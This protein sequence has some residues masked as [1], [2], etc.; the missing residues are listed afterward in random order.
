MIA[1]VTALLHSVLQITNQAS[2]LLHLVEVGIHAAKVAS[3][4][5]LRHFKLSLHFLFMV[6]QILT[7]MA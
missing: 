2:L 3:T 1:H 7:L 6:Q 4:D 5:F